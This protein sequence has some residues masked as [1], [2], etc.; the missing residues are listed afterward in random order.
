MASIVKHI[1]I[2]THPDDVWAALRDFAAVHD[3]HPN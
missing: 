1:P 3:S 2:D